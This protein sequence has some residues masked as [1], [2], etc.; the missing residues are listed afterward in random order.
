MWPDPA[1]VELTGKT[2]SDVL[3]SG[4]GLERGLQV[5]MVES[6]EEVEG[7]HRHE[8]EG[9]DRVGAVLVDVIGMPTVDGFVEATILDIPP[10]MPEGDNRRG[11]GSMGRAGGHPEPLGE[12]FFVLAIDLSTHSASFPAADHS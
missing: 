9:Q 10:G 7:H 4:L 11:G 12:Q 6:V 5:A 2:S 3:V 8:P 1:D